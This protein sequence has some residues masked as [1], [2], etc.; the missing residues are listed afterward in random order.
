MK[1]RLNFR[2][3]FMF[4]LFLMIFGFQVMAQQALQP[5][6]EESI[7]I[8]EIWSPTRVGFDLLTVG[9]LQ[10]IAYYNADRRMVVGQRNLG[11]DE[12]SMT[13]LPSKS[14]KPPTRRTSST[15][16]GWD[17]HNYIVLATD[18][19][20]YIH[21]AGNL[22]ASPLTYFRSEKP[23][24]ISTLQQIDVMVGP[25]EQRT[26]YPKFKTTPEGELLF[27]YRDGGSGRG[28]EIYNIYDVESKTWRR[29]FDTPLVSGQGKMNAYQRGPILGPDGNYHLLWMWRNTPDVATNHNLSYARSKDLRNWEGACGTELTLPITLDQKATIVDPVP[30]G[31]GLHNSHHHLA[32]DRQGRPVVTYFKH[33]ESGDTQAHAARFEDGKWN[34]RPISDWQGRHIFKG[35]GSGPATFGTSLSVRSARQHGDDLLAVPF[36]HWKAG[37]GMLVLDEQTLEPVDIVPQPEIYPTSIRQVESDFQ[38]M[39]VNWRRGRGDQP[40]DGGFYVLRWETLPPNRDRPRP[41]PWPENSD[42]VLYRIGLEPTDP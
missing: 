35:G 3:H 31:G 17:S 21:L 2:S 24:D 38:G 33:D 16:Q 4:F 41:K 18:S 27:H 10:Y 13:I 7:W 40:A 42:L 37:S 14:D 19:Q 12:F 9:D 28:N 5:V 20:G 6:I 36:S 8:D 39:R 11:D 22:H 25:N 34:I 26:T 1:N 23:H 15:I 29:F 32:F 30:P